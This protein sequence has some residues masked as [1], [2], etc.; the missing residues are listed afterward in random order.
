MS[1]FAFLMRYRDSVLLLYVNWSLRGQHRA[2]LKLL[3]WKIDVPNL[4]FR[5]YIWYERDLARATNRM[6]Y[7]V[8]FL[9]MELESVGNIRLEEGCSTD[10]WYF[11]CSVSSTV[12]VTTMQFTVTNG[13]YTLLLF[14]FALTDRFT[15]CCDLLLSRFSPSD[16]KTYG[17]TDIRVNRVIRIHNSALR[18][19]FEDKIHRLLASEDLSSQ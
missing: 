2:K 12:T 7:T 19:C 8:Q 13:K 5:I 14:S 3:I 1:E 10:P 16:Y 18:L 11:Y 9:L 17:I 6:E 15:S 4:I